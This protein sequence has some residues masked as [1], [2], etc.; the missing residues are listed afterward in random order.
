MKVKVTSVCLCMHVCVYVCTDR[1]I[2][3]WGSI[4]GED[5]FT[6]L[7]KAVSAQREGVLAVNEKREAAVYIICD[8]QSQEEL[9][10]FCLSNPV[11]GPW[12]SLPTP[13]RAC[14]LGFQSHL[15]LDEFLPVNKLRA[16][17]VAVTTRHPGRRGEHH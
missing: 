5:S 15:G 12:V 11:S 3:E 9:Q 8:E 14:C 7:Q 4:C 2:N 17:I 13:Q 10:K 16:A 6:V 1:E